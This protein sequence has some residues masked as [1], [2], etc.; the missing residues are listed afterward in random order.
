MSEI[1]IRKLTEEDVE[2]YREIRLEMLLNKPEAFGEAYEESIKKEVGF[3]EGRIKNSYIAGAFEGGKLIATAGYFIKEGLKSQ[4]KAFL[5]G[6]YV[7]E[8]YRGRGL[9]YDLTLKV[10]SDL[11]STIS[12][13][14]T[15][16]VSGNVAAEKIYQKAGFSRWATEEKALSINGKY[17]DEIHMVKF[18]D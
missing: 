5:W 10:L 9:S 14:Q 16:V 2:A 15:A 4:H 8:I 6:V 3:F 1:Q 12:L 17:Y 18:L 11:P 13:I 7:Q